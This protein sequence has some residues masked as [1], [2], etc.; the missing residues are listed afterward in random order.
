MLAPE[1]K[2]IAK[3]KDSAKPDAGQSEQTEEATQDNVQA[4]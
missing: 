3:K 2:K 4:E 1:S